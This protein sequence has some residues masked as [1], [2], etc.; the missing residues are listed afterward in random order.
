M[1]TAPAHPGL[2]VVQVRIH[3]R[4]LR[5]ITVTA[6]AVVRVLAAGAEDL[7]VNV[8]GLGNV[9]VSGLE[10][11]GL[12]MRLTGGGRIAAAGRVG[13]LVIDHAG[14]R[15]G[16]PDMFSGPV[17]VREIQAQIAS[18]PAP[19]AIDARALT[20]R[21]RID[22]TQSGDRLVALAGSVPR[23]AAILTGPGSLAGEALDV[24]H[25]DIRITGSGHVRLGRLQA[26]DAVCTG[27]GTLRYRGTPRL[28]R[29]ITGR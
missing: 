16:L 14:Q 3:P 8:T 6:P 25:A 2:P 26:L 27:T 29:I 17:D 1:I 10:A 9:D 7:E 21:E 20:V 18:S 15:A 23:L 28:G 24:E 19:E 4:D 22:L 12:T 11:A 5:R 13:N